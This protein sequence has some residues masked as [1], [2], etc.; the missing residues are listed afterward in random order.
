MKLF[1]I[2]VPKGLNAFCIIHATQWENFDF[3]LR[4]E[5]RKKLLWV[6]RRKE[7]ILGYLPKNDEKRIHALKG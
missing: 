1:H 6:G 7:P 2:A 3:K 4:R 5:H